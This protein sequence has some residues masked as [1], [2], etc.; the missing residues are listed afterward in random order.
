M[1]NIEILAKEGLKFLEQKN[2][3][4]ASRKFIEMYNCTKRDVLQLQNVTEDKDVG[5]AFFSLLVLNTID[6][7]DIKQRIASIA[8]LFISKEIHKTSL[9]SLASQSMGIDVFSEYSKNIDSQCKYFRVLLLEH[10]QEPL[11]YTVMF[12]NKI[13]RKP[14]MS[15][16]QPYYDACAIVNSMKYADLKS[17]PSLRTKK[18]LRDI[19]ERMDD[20]LS[21]DIFNNKSPKK[22]IEQGE[23]NHII[24]LYYL[25]NKVIKNGN[26]DFSDF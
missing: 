18:A 14:G 17:C 6:D 10:Y 4:N 15:I 21:N 9:T 11:A 7:I 5:I 22:L 12:A 24:L 25:E 8:Y 13:Q 3:E 19:E 23:N 16:R 26:I 20:Q 1:T 2:I